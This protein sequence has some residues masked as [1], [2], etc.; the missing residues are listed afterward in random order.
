MS[1]E[2]LR[3]KLHE[4]IDTAD[5]RHVEAMYTL[6]VREISTGYVYDEDTMQEIDRRREGLVSGKDPGYSVEEAMEI[7]RKPK[8]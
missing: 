7:A 1:T 3:G 2:E 8:K 4:Y 6:L 5:D